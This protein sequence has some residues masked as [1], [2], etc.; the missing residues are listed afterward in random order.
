M[1]VVKATLGAD[2][3]PELSASGPLVDKLGFRQVAG[4][5]SFAQWFNDVPGVNMSKKYT[6]EGLAPSGP[7]KT[8]TLG[9]GPFFPID[10]ALLG[11]VDL[12]N[13]AT[14]NEPDKLKDEAHNQLFTLEAHA[15]ITYHAGANELMIVEADDDAWVFING[16]LAIDNGGV[17]AATPVLV[18]LD[19]AAVTLGL[20]SGKVYPI[21]IFYAD[22][23]LFGATLRIRSNMTFSKCL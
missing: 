15:E 7:A 13:P 16:R 22:R 11:N 1:G 17:H 14:S 9:S 23:K 4:P 21:D 20:E 5:T 8:Y 2:K 6:F 10:G 18:Q 12:V 19:K 3:K